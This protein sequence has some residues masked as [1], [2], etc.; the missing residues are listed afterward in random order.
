MYIPIR[1]HFKHTLGMGLGYL[2]ITAWS[3]LLNP[4]S[5]A[6]PKALNSGASNDK[7]SR[8]SFHR[9]PIKIAMSESV[10]VRA[11]DS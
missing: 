11:R 3:L 4:V 9:K 2:H 8:F 6:R 5:W 1:A 10:A 7:G